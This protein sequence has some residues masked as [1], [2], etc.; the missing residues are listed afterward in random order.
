MV[1]CKARFK[2]RLGLRKTWVF[3][4]VKVR[5]KERVFLHM[6]K[7]VVFWTKSSIDAF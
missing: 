1:G 3:P 2:V 7:I 6:M 5:V 4:K